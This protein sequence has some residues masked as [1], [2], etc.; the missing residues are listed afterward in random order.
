MTQGQPPA[1]GTF[2]Y[3]DFAQLPTGQFNQSELADF[4]KVV[5]VRAGGS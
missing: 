4:I 3:F 1:F 2:G 5:L